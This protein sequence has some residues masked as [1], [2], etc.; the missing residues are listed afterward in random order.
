[1]SRTAVL[2]F[3]I[4]KEIRPLAGVWL[5]CLVAMVA[6][7][8]FGVGVFRG[9]G[10]S[11][12]FLGTAALG[13]LSIGHE[14]SHRT[15]TMLLS[16]PARRERLF[17]VKMGV[18][19]AMLLT[20]SAVARFVVDFREPE[21][22][23][24][25]LAVLPMLCALFIAPWLTMLCRNPIA[26]A[27]FAFVPLGWLWVV[28][29][30]LYVAIHGR[31]PSIDVAMMFVWTEALGLCAVGAVMSW[32]MFMRLEAIDGGGTEVRLP[33]WLRR[34]STTNIAASAPR[35]RHPVWLLL[36]KEI[37]LQQMS[38]AVTG[39]YVLG[40][41]TLMM[42]RHSVQ[43][44][45]EI[46]TV[47]TFFYGA[48]MPVLIGSLASAEERQLGTLEWQALLPVATRTQWTVKAGTAI[49]LA[50]LLAIGVPALLLASIDPAGVLRFLSR[51]GFT[52]AIVALT[53]VSL[54]VSTLCTS[55][56]RAVLT[57]V[58]AISAVVF[59]VGSVVQALVSSR[60]IS[61]LWWAPVSMVARA[62][63]EKAWQR[64][65]IG[66]VDFS[67]LMG[68]L[69]L[70]LV[71]IILAVVLRFALANHRSADPAGGRV[72][73]QTILVG[74]WL[75]VG[76]LLLGGMALMVM[77]YAFSSNTFS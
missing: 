46:F 9:L 72:W 56:L 75:T 22:A 8:V 13:A 54:Y 70:L 63:R 48:S 47:L 68:T 65:G 25:A 61:L 28:S 26:G 39:L 23:R 64:F 5:A 20:I 14:Y 44:A 29:E 59:F 1:M 35:K 67:Q 6:T 16:Q 58:S 32:R 30:R 17:L 57:S 31:E 41:L 34:R 51:P 19:A 11:A 60:R 52:V 49:G 45:D 18:L 37:G 74:V 53:V 73:T 3:D 71:A 33:R 2:P 77:G 38:L 69:E 62:S 24:L 42:V 76:A 36:K 12:Y 15:L 4:A 50:L 10:T 55:G 27:V 40:W 21:P 66:P 7:A 43:H